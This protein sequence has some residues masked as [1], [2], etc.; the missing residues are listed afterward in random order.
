M[1]ARFKIEAIQNSKVM[2]T[3]AMICDVH[4]PRLTGSPEYLQAANWCVDQLNEWGI[5]SARL[6]SWQDSKNAWSIKKFNIEMTAPRYDRLIGY[7]KAWTPGTNGVISGEPKLVDIEEEED[8]DKYRGELEGKI[9]LNGKVGGSNPSFS[10]IAER[11]DPDELAGMKSALNTAKPNVYNNSEREYLKKMRLRNRF[12][13]KEGVA[14]VIEPS[15]KDHTIIAAMSSNPSA[16]PDSTVP[17]FMISKEQYGRIQRI[18]AAETPVTL[19]LD[20]ETTFSADS[21]GQ[22]VIAEIP[23]ADRKL[24]DQVVMIGAHLDSWHAGT[25]ATDNGG[26]CAVMMEVMRII[27]AVGIEP[28]RTIRLGLWGGEEQGYLGSRGYVEKHFG[29]PETLELLPGHEK[30]SAYLNLDNGSG[31]IRGIYL[32]GNEY[33]RPIFKQLLEPFDYLDAATITSQSTN[34]TDHIPFNWIGLPAFQFIQDPIEYSRTWHTNIDVYEALLPD[35]LKQNVA[36]VASLVYLLAMR[37]EMMP[38]EA[39]PELPTEEEE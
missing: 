34:G 15:W 25:G 30:L 1:I 7:P 12:Y 35:E 32:Q 8:F 14:A 10:A 3:V 31:R 23:G 4:G 18:L 2:Q 13:L 38:R 17:S 11:V 5:E 37:D 21:I 26:N 20:L 24:K 6:E 36:I 27:K 19:K 16:D 29:D 9:I 28:R 33:A 39:M 22:N